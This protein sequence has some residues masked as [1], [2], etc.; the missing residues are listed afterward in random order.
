MAKENDNFRAGV[1]LIVCLTLGLAII[2]ILSDVERLITPD[3]DVQVRYTLAD[4][5][6]GLKVGSTVNM[7][8]V[9]VG[10]VTG[11]ENETDEEGSVTAQIA[12]FTM[13]EKFRM[14]KNA[15]IELERP[16]IGSGTVLNIRSVGSG[17]AYDPE[18]PPIAGRI[19]PSDLIQDLVRE[20]GIREEQKE[21][22]RQ[23]IAN[24]ERITD[25]V[26]TDLPGMTEQAKAGLENFRATSEGTKEIVAWFDRVD[27]ISTNVDESVVMV[28]EFLREK[29]PA[30]RNTVDNA[31]A[32]SE[33]FRE[34][35]MEQLAEV[36]SKADHTMANAKQITEEVKAFTVQQRPTME[37]ALAS[38]QLTAAQ[39]KLA[40][41]EIRRSPWRLLYQPKEQELESD[42]LYDAARSFAQAAEV[43]DSTAESLQSVVGRDDMPQEEVKRLIERL[44]R[45]FERYEEAEK[46][47][48]D[49]LDAPPAP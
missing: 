37:R 17:T 15:V 48:W 31:E 32:V 12:S 23:I 33:R 34:E 21:Q 3:Q 6:D 29:T 35:S 47:F 27:T 36:M 18:G 44:D 38:L 8:G 24:F 20:M 46:A 9:P 26:R 39:L 43:L 7:G 19:A 1:F 30:L 25:Q 28:R 41:I 11:I 5:V 14:F 13:P 40:A 16:P 42:N 49:A 22:F 2:F 45:L 4:G 10:A